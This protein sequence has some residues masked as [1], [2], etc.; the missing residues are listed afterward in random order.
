MSVSGDDDDPT[1]LP[2]LRHA[3]VVRAEAAQRDGQIERCAAG[4]GRAPVRNFDGIVTPVPE[5]AAREPVIVLQ[6]RELISVTNIDR[7][8]QTTN[9]RGGA[10]CLA[11]WVRN[12]RQSTGG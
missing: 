11:C 8:R 9:R 1:G 10:N 2:S 7:V 12:G 6:T 3:H 5:S 4:D